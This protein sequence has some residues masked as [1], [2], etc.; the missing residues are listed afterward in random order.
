MYH[1]ITNWQSSFIFFFHLH[2]PVLSCNAHCRFQLIM[3]MTQM[4][5]ILLVTVKYSNFYIDLFHLIN[6]AGAM[7]FFPDPI[8]H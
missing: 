1:T 3:K 4:Y 5:L 7:F 2:F 8:F 6:Y